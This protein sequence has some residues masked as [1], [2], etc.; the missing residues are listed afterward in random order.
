MGFTIIASP[1]YKRFSQYMA[2]HAYHIYRLDFQD[3]EYTG[4]LEFQLKT[5]QKQI[6]AKVSECLSLQQYWLRQQ[7][8]LVRMVKD[9]TSESTEIESSK[10]Q[11]TILLQKKLRIEGRF[12]TYV[13][14][15]SK[16]C[17]EILCMIF[18]F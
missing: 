5:L 10:K 9:V 14:N 6:D 17:A 3:E 4:P 13:F 2:L 8:E 15:F 1:F 18:L 12:A 11:S 7:N 16:S